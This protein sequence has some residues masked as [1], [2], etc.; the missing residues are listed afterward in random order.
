M[1]STSVLKVQEQSFADGEDDQ[2]SSASL[3]EIRNVKCSAVVDGEQ[4]AFKPG[5]QVKVHYGNSHARFVVNWVGKA[6]TIQEGHLG[7]QSLPSGRYIWDLAL[8]AGGNS[9]PHRG[10]HPKLKVCR[11][12]F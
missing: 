7:L 11:V 6:G 8:R 9:E 4:S 3:V 12:S 1:A 5:D 10:R 2:Y